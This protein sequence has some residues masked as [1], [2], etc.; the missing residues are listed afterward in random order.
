[1][2]EISTESVDWFKTLPPAHQRAGRLFL[3]NLRGVFE[4]DGH[5]GKQAHFKKPLIALLAE[6]AAVTGV[7]NKDMSE[8]LGTSETTVQ[9][10]RTT[11]DFSEPLFTQPYA[12]DVKRPRQSDLVL[13]GTRRVMRTIG[14]RS[15]R[16]YLVR[17]ED[18]CAFYQKY[19]NEF[20][21]QLPNEEP[22]CKAIFYRMFYYEN[23]YRV[24]I[25]PRFNKCPTCLDLGDKENDGTITADEQKEFDAHRKLIGL[26][27]SAH[28]R[29]RERLKR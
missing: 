18:E 4:Y 23:Y 21:K 20:K 22:V 28:R 26:Q 11:V 17:D 5:F 14:A 16:E 9:T 24:Q 10:A 1:M 19:V 8:F 2:K 3:E 13:D 29:D 6:N 25:G 27:N 7:T 15:G 12:R